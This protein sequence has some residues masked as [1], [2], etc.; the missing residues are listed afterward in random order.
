MGPQTDEDL[1]AARAPAVSLL[2]L[3]RGAGLGPV[4]T[5]AIGG[6][7]LIVAIAI[8]T[9]VAVMDFRD[10]ALDTSKQQLENTV[11]LLSRHFEH[12]LHDF[13]AVPEAL[14]KE[15]QP[16]T[17]LSPQDFARAMASSQT[18]TLLETKLSGL[19]DVV[20]VSIWG[21]DG[22][23][24][25]SSAEWPVRKVDITD[26][27]YFRVMKGDPA[28]QHT[29]ALLR[30]RLVGNW[31]IVFGQRIS[32]PTGAFLG[33]MTRGVS[34]KS[35]EAF[36]DSVE[37]DKDASIAFLH[38]DGTLMA[39]IPRMDAMIGRKITID[40]QAVAPPEHYTLQVVSPVDKVERIVAVRHIPSLPIIITASTTVQAALKEWRQQT[41]FLVGVG[42]LGAVVIA[43][44]LSLIIRQLTRQH[45]ASRSKLRLEK[46]R[47]ATAVNN[48]TQ[49]LLLFDSSA[50]LVMCNERYLDMFEGSRDV[51]KPG[52]SL[53][54]LVRHRKA[55]GTFRGDVDEYCASFLKELK[56]GMP[57]KIVIEADRR[58]IEMRY[59]PLSEGGWVTTAEDITERQRYEDRIS[60][61]AHY[62]SLTDL[63]NRALFRDRLERSLT[64]MKAVETLAVLYIDVDEFKGIN[65]SLGHP[66][67]D[68]LL[69]SIAARLCSCAGAQDFVAR[70]GGDEFAVFRP[71]AGGRDDVLPLINKIHDAIRRPAECLG[72]HVVVDASIGVAFA[73]SGMR[74]LDQLVKN[75]DLALYEAKSGGRRTWRFFEAAMQERA[76]A[77]RTGE[78]ELRKAIRD[79]EL[80]VHYQPIIDFKTEAVV[81]CEA[82]IR[83]RH[84]ERGMISP[85]QFIPV[86]EDTGLINEIGEWVLRSACAMAVTWP[87]HTT[88][89]VNVS[90]MQFR[91]PGFALKVVGAL[92]ASGLAAHRLE[93]EVT[94][95]V[96]IN[97]DE[98]TLALL[99]ELRA[100][101]VRIALDDFGTGYS[102]LS[103]LQRFPFDKIKIDRSFV[104]NVA[105]SQDSVAI[106]R[107]VVDIAG[108]RNIA[109][110]AEGVET[111]EQKDTL[112]ALGC[113]QMQ[114]YL[115]SPAV[116]AAEIGALVSSAA[117]VVA[118]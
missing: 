62:D 2:G 3:M 40:N 72:H 84:P 54:D 118:A 30:N 43:L 7:T 35:I 58:T 45:R 96:L 5:L 48:M 57:G 103:H 50:H 32:S 97:D 94:E 60:H 27:E 110:T 18:H 100:L 41:R 63:P 111:V 12:Y 47:F 105:W 80:E 82:L 37:S 61:M 114:G 65:D 24:L 108:V 90:P 68:E 116:P 86:A 49:G 4:T 66:V 102:S 31:T 81:G 44:T 77:R 83:W 19:A 38:T 22:S 117:K 95:T 23:L 106:V 78:I 85:A 34:P 52:C 56:L 99:N 59:Q 76:N 29:V 93:L 10:R 104:R 51:V 21:A 73:S 67:G 36:L 14:I 75:A 101:G 107:A 115:F 112:R 46:E 69:K 88:I 113:A 25:N 64:A 13:T 71:D 33:V 16:L 79:G 9:F 39:R 17:D 98:T 109:T 1:D 74:D 6:A 26:R 55:A 8:G 89:A 15:F 20:G 11:L 92:G 28:T 42:A 87:A 91:E 53:R 70:L